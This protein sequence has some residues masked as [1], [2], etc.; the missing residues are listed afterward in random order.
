MSKVFV[1]DFFTSKYGYSMK[2]TEKNIEKVREK[3]TEALNS[4]EVGGY[5]NLNEINE[6]KRAETASKFGRDIEQTASH[7]FV[8]SPASN[9]ETA[10]PKFTPKAA[11]VKG[12]AKVER[13]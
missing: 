9:G 7:V 11:P 3:M 10:K 13:F 4:L 1:G 12:S 6:D 2:I 5:L 8:V